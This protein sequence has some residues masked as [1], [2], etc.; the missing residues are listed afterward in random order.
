M[1]V[2]TTRPDGGHDEEADRGPFLHVEGE[3]E[4][5]EHRDLK[6]RLAIWLFIGGDALF[7]LLEL[8]GWFYLRALNTNGMWRGVDCTKANPCT[9]GLGNPITQEI[10]KANPWYSVVVAALAVVAA[11]LIW[12]MERAARNSEQRRVV[13]SLGGLALIALLA[14][15]AVGFYQFQHLPFVTTL[16]AYASSY[17]FFIGSSLVHLI[18]LTLIGFGLWN[19]ARLGRYDGGKYFQVRLIRQF[20]VWIAIS[21]CVLALVSSVYG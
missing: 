8:F 6:E 14:S 9:D 13:S 20:A 2:T 7:L 16:G 18:L 4:S 11:V 19:R 10:A 21:V 12:L 1:S 5:P 17:E 3:H 15:V